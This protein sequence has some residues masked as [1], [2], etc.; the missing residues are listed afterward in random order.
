M[1]KDVTEL[2]PES[3]VDLYVV[4]AVLCY[5]AVSLSI[6][7]INAIIFTKSLKLPIFVSLVQILVAVVILVTFSVLGRYFKAFS[8][9]PPL[10]FEAEKVKAVLPVTVAYTLMLS[11]NNICLQFVQVSTYQVARS[12]TI[13]FNI[14]LTRYLLHE[15]VSSLTKMACLVVM[16]GFIAGSLDP[17]TLSLWGATAGTVGSFFWALYSCSVKKV[18]KETMGGNE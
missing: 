7:F 16:S 17:T 18:M 2:E 1:T 8:F 9:M 10:E 14:V 11:F 12:T 15:E 6:V 4:G 13:L 5:F 3:P